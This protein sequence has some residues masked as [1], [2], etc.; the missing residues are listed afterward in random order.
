MVS[1]YKRQMLGL[2]HDRLTESRPL[3]KK[4][5]SVK[6]KPNVL[7]GLI[8]EINSMESTQLRNEAGKDKL[9]GGQG[10]R[11]GKLMLYQKPDGNFYMTLKGKEAEMDSKLVKNR[12]DAI[13]AA[14]MFAKMINAR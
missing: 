14:T 3:A 6:Q 9:I 5:A 10:T 11:Q 4:A 8:N 2:Y 12:S 1:K 7:D 13:K